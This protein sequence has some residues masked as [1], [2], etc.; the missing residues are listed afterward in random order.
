LTGWN[1]HVD[2]MDQWHREKESRLHARE[3]GRAGPLGSCGRTHRYWQLDPRCRRQHLSGLLRARRKNGRWAGSVGLGPFFFFFS[4]FFSLF[5]FKF[6]FSFLL[7]DFKFK[8]E[9]QLCICTYIKCANLHLGMK[10]L[11][12][13]IYLFPMFYVV[14]LFFFHS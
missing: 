3:S 14:F 2:P 10:R 5:L 1:G 12:L 13:C 9:F 4:L 7:L 8:F 6:R 11:Y